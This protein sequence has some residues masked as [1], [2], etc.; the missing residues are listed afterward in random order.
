MLGRF[1]GTITLWLDSGRKKP[2]YLAEILFQQILIG[3]VGFYAP[4]PGAGEARSGWLVANRIHGP[5]SF[6]SYTLQPLFQ[7]NE[8]L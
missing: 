7:F 5:C 1:E 6:L 8:I 4:V 3:M 2:V